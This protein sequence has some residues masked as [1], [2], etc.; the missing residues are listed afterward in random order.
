MGVKV[1][2]QMWFSWEI[3]CWTPTK[4][5]WE[6]FWLEI[7]DGPLDFSWCAWWGDWW[8]NQAIISI[9]V[10]TPLVNVAT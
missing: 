5:M 7:P 4:G 2:R 1:G 3:F 10:E 6:E 9:A 8:W